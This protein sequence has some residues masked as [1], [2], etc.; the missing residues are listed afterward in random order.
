MTEQL[1]FTPYLLI[2]AGIWF[3]LLN[4]YLIKTI[5]S[6]RRL[7]RG[8]S[9][10]NLEKI[11]ENLGKNLD[12]NDKR[13]S[14]LSKDVADQK[15][16]NPSNFQKL[17]L[18]RFNPFEETGGD[19]SFVAALLDGQNNGIIISSLHSRNGTRVYAKPVANGKS[20]THEFSKEEKEVVEK[21]ARPSLTR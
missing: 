20:T 8:A 3:A 14:Q 17:Q 9:N 7:T 16:Q 6:Y 15:R 11:L 12:L 2:A 19:Q 21:A 1:L 10:L 4:F 18:L 5:V 13:I